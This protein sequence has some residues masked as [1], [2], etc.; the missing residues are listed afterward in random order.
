MDKLNATGR[1]AGGSEL[2]ALDIDYPGADGLFNMRAIKPV[3]F[4]GATGDGTFDL[5]GFDGQILDGDTIQ[6]YLINQRPPL[7]AFNNIIDA[8]NIGANTT[9]EVF[10]TRRG[11][12]QMRHLRTIWSTALLTS[13]RVAA[14]EGGAFL[15]TND[16]SVRT[17]WV[18][19]TQLNLL[20]LRITHL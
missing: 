7:G 4:T 3:G 6:F 2:I 14:L 18:C 20:V 12:D 15:V 5:L 11:E 17:G 1:R 8:S 10:E 13:N 16:H 19:I 9:I